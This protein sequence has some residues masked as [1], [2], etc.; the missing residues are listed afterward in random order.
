MAASL[1]SNRKANKLAEFEIGGLM[2][3]L[4]E[5]PVE[6]IHLYVVRE[7]AKR[8]FT[9]VPLFFAVL[10]LVGIA[11]LTI[12]SAKH[13]YY[14]HQTLRIPVQFL[15]IQHFGTTVSLIPTGI[16][17]YPATQAHGMLTLTN[18]SVLSEELPKG[19][20]FTGKDGAEVVTQAQV[21]IP[22]GSASGYGV[23]TVPAQA[24]VSGTQ[25]NIAA[26]SINA[27]YGTSLYIR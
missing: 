23:A 4:E 6:T 26:F 11:A 17:T 19:I 27:V 1:S 8:P 15:P 9:V 7:E 13:P 3:T 20:I 5:P 22:P 18:G 2:E 12:Y 21:Y 10:C 24:V 16:K 14:E 25:G